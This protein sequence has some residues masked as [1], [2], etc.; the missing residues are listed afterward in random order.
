M[1]G[2]PALAR[3]RVGHHTS[4]KEADP[5]GIRFSRMGFLAIRLLL[6][7]LVGPFLLAG[8]GETDPEAPTSSSLAPAVEGHSAEPVLPQF[9][10]FELPDDW[11]EEHPILSPNAKTE[12]HFMSL[13]DRA[14]PLNAGDGAGRAWTEAVRAIDLEAALST[15]RRGEGQGKRAIVPASS[16]QRIE[17]IFEVGPEGIEEGGMIFVMPEPFWSWSVAQVQDPKAFGYTTAISQSAGVDLIPLDDGAAFRVEGRALEPGERVDIVLGA[18]PPGTIVDE[19]AE[20]GSEILIAVDAD[21]DGIRAWIKDS[22]RI[23][24]TARPGQAF[25]ALGPA[26]VAPGG[27]IELSISLVD[28]R[29]NLARWPLSSRD[30]PDRSKI[31]FSIETIDG[32]SLEA[33]G[34]DELIYGADLA[35]GPYRLRFAAPESEGT[36]RLS[37]R[38]RGALEGMRADVNPIVVRESTTRLIWADLHGHSSLSD[39]TGTPE[40]YFTYAR[41]VA[42]LDAIALTDHDHW[43]IR[44]LDDSAELAD[45]ILRTALRFHDRGRFVTIPG[46]EWTSW[47]HGHR[48]VL[49]FDEE[50]PIHSSIDFATDRPDELWK[51]LRGQP[52]LT[53]AHHSAGEPVATNWSFRPDPELEPLTEVSSVHGMSEAADAPLPV[54]GAIHGNF[55]RDVLLRGARFG[56]VG[57]GD[58]HDGHP[59]LAQ[60]AAGGQSGLAGIFTDSLDRPA[61]LQAMR[62]RRTFATNGIRPWLSVTIDETFMG[63]SFSASA[64]LAAEHRLRIRY[65]ATSPIVRVDLIR[66][67]RVASLEG[68]NGLED[69]SGLDDAGGLESPGDPESPSDL[70]NPGDPENPSGTENS[71][72]LTLDFERAIPRLAP[73]EFH[74]VRVLEEGGGVAW[75]SPIF[76]DVPT[77]AAKP[78]N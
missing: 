23:D 1:D 70:E 72:G 77:N 32:P 44:P 58:S 15:W 49:Y 4:S 46:Y 71:N 62:K 29:G 66:S 16:A 52:A 3:I 60:L 30:D 10:S 75:S 47:I 39:G 24:I 64:D 18:G 45:H 35:D 2:G 20:R 11:N 41:D 25:V 6:A 9:P 56:F 68:P 55:V 7:G 65:E 57:S 50:A 27:S 13:A 53:F 19:F 38:G 48:H 21:G 67:G 28:L 36:I 8:C 76:V 74:Y 78:L 34:L 69:P 63:G 37:V 42:R 26:E 22:A 51:A 31:A 14:A 61:L 54:Y 73:G 12:A 17:L 43:G 33:P 59:G 5:L 40:D